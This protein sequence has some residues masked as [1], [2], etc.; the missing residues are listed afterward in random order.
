MKL[1]IFMVRSSKLVSSVVLMP[2]GLTNFN[3]GMNMQYLIDR[4]KEPSSWRGAI[5][6]AM[7]FGLQLSPDQQTAIITV[8]LGIMGVIGAFFPDLGKDD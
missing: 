4:F 7:A 3:G 8:G 5:A 6:L 2:Y 1:T